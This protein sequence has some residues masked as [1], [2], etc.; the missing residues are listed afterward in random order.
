MPETD[1][2]SHLREIPYLCANGEGVSHN[3]AHIEQNQLSI[4]SNG[5]D[6]LDEEAIEENLELKLLTTAGKT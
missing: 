2:I 6:A 4:T 1:G 3:H 5:K